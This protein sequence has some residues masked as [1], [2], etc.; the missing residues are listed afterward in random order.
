MIATYHLALDD[1]EAFFLAYRLFGWLW[2]ILYL[3]EQMKDV[4]RRKP[5]T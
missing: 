3:W 5:Q 2:R 1:P 4:F